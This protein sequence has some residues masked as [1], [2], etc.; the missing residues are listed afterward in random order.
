MK[1]ICRERTR[2][3]VLLPGGKGGKKVSLLFSWLHEEG[4]GFSVEKKEKKEE[5]Q[6]KLV[7]FF[8]KKERKKGGGEEGWIPVAG[9]GGNV[10]EGGKA[11]D[12]SH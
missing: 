7:T 10:G 11:E 12:F 1:V 6:P 5:V 3:R 4:S 2:R 8:R 9:P